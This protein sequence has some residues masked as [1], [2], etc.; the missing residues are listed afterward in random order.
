MKHALALASFFVVAFASNAFGYGFKPMQSEALNQRLQGCLDKLACKTVGNTDV[1]RKTSGNP[2]Q[3]PTSCHLKC[4][5]IDIYKISC[6]DGGDNS[7]N[8]MKVAKCLSGKSYLTCYNGFG[9]C[10]ARHEDHLHFGADEGRQCKVPG[11]G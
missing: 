5:A 2:D 9:G 1:C 4:R 8:L 6:K 3:S 10:H 11:E 7:S